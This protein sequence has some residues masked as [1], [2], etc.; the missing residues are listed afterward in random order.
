MAAIAKYR[1]L[2]RELLSRYA[3]LVATQNTADVE[4][5]LAFDEEHDQ[6]LWLEVG[7]ED[8]HRVTRTIVHARIRDG[9]IWIEQDWTEDG[10]ASDLW[11][12]GVP[13]DAIVLAFYEP[14]ERVMQPVALATSGMPVSA[15]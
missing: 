4:T 3:D 2:I 10:I 14:Q 13:H 1:A 12:A 9:V 7:W 5:L 8:R 11:R 15:E 6:Y